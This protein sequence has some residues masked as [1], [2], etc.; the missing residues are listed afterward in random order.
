M[1]VAFNDWSTLK[2]QLATL[3]RTRSE[4]LQLLDI[5]RFQVNEIKSAALTPGEDRRSKKKSDV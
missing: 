2:S 1:A 5:L 4:K 3:E